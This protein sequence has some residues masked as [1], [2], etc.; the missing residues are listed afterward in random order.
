[1]SFSKLSEQRLAECHPD[2]QKI[3]QIVSQKYPCTI[4]QGHRNQADQHTAFVTGKS[5]LD[6]PNG[7][8]NKLPSNAVDA[9]PD[10]VNYSN[11]I[12]N[13]VRFYNFA[14]YVQRVADELGIKIRYGG[15]WDSDKDFSDQKFDDLVH[16]EL[17]EPGEVWEKNSGHLSSPA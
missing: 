11:A 14:G 1:M 16:F 2:L 15:D 12:K 6:W 10:P 4:T 9:C 8:H 13:I 3:F 7:N 5:K 17:V